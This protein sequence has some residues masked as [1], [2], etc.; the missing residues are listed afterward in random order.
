MTDPRHFQLL[1]HLLGALDDEEQER[2]DARLENDSEYCQEL[3]D[4]RRRLTR[5][6]PLRPEY[7]PP[8][9]LA[10]R[11]CR[12]VAA[13]AE[14]TGGSEALPK[15]SSNPLPPT[16]MCSVGWV[17]S[18]VLGVL[19]TT[20]VGLIFPAIGGSRFQ[21]RLASCQDSLRQF[22]TAMMHYGRQQGHSL[23]W[24]ADSGRLTAEGAKAIELLE[25]GLLGAE[26][27]PLCPD[28]WLTAQGVVRTPFHRE[29]HSET[30]LISVNPQT[31]GVCCLRTDWPGMWRNGTTNG[32]QNASLP[33][34]MPLLAD[35]PSADL[36]GQSLAGHDGRGRNV[37]FEDG[38]VVFLPVQTSLDGS[39]ALLPA[40]DDLATADLATPIA[41]VS[42]R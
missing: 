5:L 17:D 32:W 36:P 33:T 18:I 42:R 39:T 15:M 26:R 41:F 8:A 22:G 29:E 10:N 7:E 11:T 28:A 31:Q 24:L 13:Y 4:W 6:E 34:T 19:L 23:G 16:R 25:D 1:G 40:G 30:I 20:A 27:R 38:R 35:A 2:V 14:Q 3:V 9:D 37:L 21:A 12:R